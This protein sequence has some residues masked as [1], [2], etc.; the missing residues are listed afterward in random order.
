MSGTPRD[1]DSTRSNDRPKAA[2]ASSR[3]H[4]IREIAPGILAETIA[5]A[6]YKEHHNF[7]GSLPNSKG[8][9]A[10]FSTEPLEVIYANDSY[11]DLN[12]GLTLYGERPL[13]ETAVPRRALKKY[14]A[15][16]MQQLAAAATLDPT[17]V[18]LPLASHYKANYYHWW[19]DSVSKFFICNKSTVFQSKMRNSA[20][21]IFPPEQLTRFQRQ[22]VALLNKDALFMERGNDRFVR[23]RSVNSGGLHCYGARRVNHM[24]RG[25][26]EYL[27]LAIPPSSTTGAGGSG[28]LLYIS[29]NERPVRRILNEDELVP[30][31]RDL[32]F[33][34]VHP[35]TLSLPDQIATFRNAQVIVSAHGAGLA[36]ILFCRPGTSIVE[37]FPKSGI[38]A[39]SFFRIASHLDF[40][41]YYIAC[42]EVVIE[43]RKD[44]DPFG[45]NKNM[46]VD[47]DSFVGFLREVVSESRL[48][49]PKITGNV[50]NG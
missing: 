37:L 20:W 17:V 39:S 28:D 8:I 31:L 16:T 12:A 45:A 9:E 1:I 6:S 4:E 33:H 41:Y 7:R 18:A 43:K 49:G 40:S 10:G 3:D 35:A 30:P 22:T 29:R 27:N 46:I 25:F 11:L 42:Q 24:V 21:Q 50:G 19:L 44:K 5:P 32:G 47:R 38:H 15:P 26:A 2:P 36:N 23:G 13:E 48:N 34:V 14:V